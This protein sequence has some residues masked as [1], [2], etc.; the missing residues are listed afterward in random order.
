M[1]GCGMFNDLA[2]P[3]ARGNGDFLFSFPPFSKGDKNP[4]EEPRR[5]CCQHFDIIWII[6]QP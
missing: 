5:A 6:P 3:I 1:L 2:L 4:Q